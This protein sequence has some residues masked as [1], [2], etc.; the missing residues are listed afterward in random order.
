[1]SK[2]LSKKDYGKIKNSAYEL[3]V[4]REYTQKQAA[5]LLS[6]SE[7]TVSEWATEGNWRE[8]RKAR[9]SAVSTANNNLKNII[10]LL[11]ERRL[12]LEYEINEAQ[13]EGDKEAELKLRK[14]ASVVSDDISKTNK[15]LE[16][17]DKN[18]RMTLGVFIDVADDIF[19]RLN[20]SG[21][22]IKC[23][24]CGTEIN[25]YDETLE[26]QTALIRQKTVE[27]G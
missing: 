16:N 19:N 5:E 15:A 24:K 7:K 17:N 27:L 3:I 14:E 23:P 25:L 9:Q 11:A 18:N 26:F 20:T 1:M 10:S 2:K 21:L 8:M 13:A 22:K 6:V 12:R 4:V